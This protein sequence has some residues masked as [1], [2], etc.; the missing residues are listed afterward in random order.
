MI[1]RCKKAGLRIKGDANISMF[2]VR[3]SLCLYGV[4][5]E[6]VVEGKMDVRQC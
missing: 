2:K 5:V 4:V 1:N 6:D 3:F